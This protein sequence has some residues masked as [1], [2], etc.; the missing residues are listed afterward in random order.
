MLFDD[1]DRQLRHIQKFD[2]NTM[3]GVTTVSHFIFGYPA[4]HTEIRD[5]LLQ[6]LPPEWHDKIVETRA[7]EINVP[8]KK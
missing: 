4:G 7:V 8:L 5:K 3:L 1:E 2:T 6:C